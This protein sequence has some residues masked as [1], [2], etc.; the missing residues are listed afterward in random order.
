LAGLLAA[1]APVLL[2]RR[3][4]VAPW[5]VA[6]LAVV[7]WAVSLGIELVYIRDHL[8]G[9][10]AA[11]RMNTVFKFGLQ[12]WILMALAAACAL[13]WLA[14]GLRRLGALAQIVGWSLIIALVGLALV[15]PLAGVPSRLAYRFPVSPGPTLDGLAFMDLAGFDIA[16]Q[17]I[18]L[19]AGSQP[20]HVDLRADADAIRWL[21][22]NIQGTPIVLQSD[23][24]FYRTYGTRVAANT[25]LPTVVSPLHASEQH[26]PSQV[27]ERDMDVHQIYRSTSPDEA[28]RLLS[29]YHVGY[30]YVGPIERAA[31]G[32]AGMLKF[33][34]MNGTY[35]RLAYQNDGVKIYAVDDGVYSLPFDSV[36]QGP[37]VFMPPAS[38]SVPGPAPTPESA[39]ATID[40][41]R[42][43]AAADPTAPGLAFALAQ[44]YRDLG[45]HDEAAATIEKAA[46]AHPS[47]VALNQLW[48]DILRD[49]GRRDESEA[50]YRAAVA[51][52]PSAG[53]Y[54]K[55]GVELLKW[56]LLDKAA[57][58]LNQAIAA[59]ANV[60]E[61]YYHLGEVY[62]KQGQTDR[63][64]EQYR[65]YLN[66]AAPD[67][68]Y[69]AAATEAMNRLGR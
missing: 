22:E 32:E 29:K 14:R 13:P 12:A 45:R 69:R 6:W 66:I 62:E 54:N 42:R 61:P 58:A 5:F 44:R 17:D 53:N 2:S 36:D 49:G 39:P 20:I 65:A 56:G 16:P 18:G 24:W 63:A 51:A 57:A 8:S 1:G 9:D 48:G 7:A 47:D 31:Y 4:P 46:R 50:A 11:Y 64:L 19:S 25:G 52:D 3:A 67:D 60:A 30:V 15:F 34:Q 41:L 21:N 27:G 40:E 10:A 43:Q 68:A 59:D 38:A 23:L 33:D 37:P 55:L 28:L 26:D 35:L